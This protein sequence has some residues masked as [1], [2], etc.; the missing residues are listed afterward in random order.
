M[1]RFQHIEEIFQEALQRDPGQ[2][3]AFV[4]NAC[5]GDDELHREV[6]SPDAFLRLWFAHIAFMFVASLTATDGI[7]GTAA[8][9]ARGGRGRPF[10]MYTGWV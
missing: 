10:I 3:E 5:Q 1:D 6:S 7:L 2:R 9:S 4:R 8:S